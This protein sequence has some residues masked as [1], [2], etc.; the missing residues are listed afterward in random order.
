VLVEGP[1]SSSSQ[2]GG[3]DENDVKLTVIEPT[4]KPTPV[5]VGADGAA[6]SGGEEGSEQEHPSSDG[7]TED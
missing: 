5:G 2:D 6:G 3:T 4:P 7:Q 1:S